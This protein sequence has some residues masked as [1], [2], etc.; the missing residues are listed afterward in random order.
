MQVGRI[1]KPLQISVGARATSAARS[2]RPQTFN[3]DAMASNQD[4]AL[5]RL[6]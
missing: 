6:G 5:P 3:G 4:G 2:A 1:K